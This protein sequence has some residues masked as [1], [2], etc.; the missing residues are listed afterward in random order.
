MPVR[1]RKKFVEL[2]GD[3]ARVAIR[4][5]ASCRDSLPAVLSDTFGGHNIR[6]VHLEADIAFAARL[7]VFE[8]V[9][10]VVDGPLRVV[11]DEAF[12]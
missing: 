11:A 5:F 12:R 6:R 8:V 10:K 3:S 9:G 2:D 4:L 1:W 7:N